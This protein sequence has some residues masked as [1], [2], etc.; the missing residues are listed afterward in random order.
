MRL[1]LVSLS[2]LLTVAVL[3][4]QNA[5]DR[6]TF[7]SGV[8]SIEVDV[9]VT[10]KD[11]KAVRGLTKDAF[12]LI[13]D[14][15]PQRIASFSFIDLPIE[16]IASRVAAAKGVESDITTNAGEGR[17]YVM[18]LN[19]AGERARLVA[20][21]FVEE[22]VGPNDQMAVIHVQGNSSAAQGF[23]KSRRLMLAAVDRID[24]GGEESVGAGADPDPIVANFRVAEEVCEKLGLVTGRR[25]I[26]LWF[27]PPSV[28]IDQSP[29]GPARM[30]A[31]RDALRAATRNNVAVY[32]VSTRGL[33]TDLSPA[34]FPGSPGGPLSY[35]AGLR[36][37]SDDT[38]GETIV[39]T[40]NFSAAFQGFVRDNSSYYLLSYEPAI[41]HRDGK[42]H[43]LTVRV[44]RPGLTVRA[45]RGY[46]APEPDAKAKPDPVVV[47]GLSDAT[48]KAIRMPS[49]IG[50]LGIE[51]LVAPFKGTA[52]NGSVLIGARLRGTDLLLGPREPLEVAFQATTTEGKVTPGAFHVMTLD[53]TPESRAEIERTGIRIV[54]RIELPKGRHQ[55]RFAVHQPNGKTGTV[56]ADV[57]IPDYSAPLV[58]SGVVIAS[59]GAVAHRT[60]L[61]DETFR[62]I[63]S[64]DP[65]PVRRFTRQDVISA[66]AEVYT[67][68]RR[69]EVA[70]VTAS[71]AT[72]NGRKG[73]APTITPV[74]GEPGRGG[75]LTSIRL[76]DLTPG[77]YVLTLDASTARGNA[78]RQ[79]PFTVIAD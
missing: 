19:G 12:T 26:V 3:R 6:P 39:D 45:R 14:D 61:I 75:Y 49:S 77:D 65:T 48:A 10:D 28:F 60:L 64:S 18:L 11:R 35:K 47:E 5:Q 74:S 44:N 46:Y 25:K 40:N 34:G 73:R 72:A 38:G 32:P 13:E 63:L 50:E 42:F 8:Q 27:D 33:T 1:R 37:L 15:T 4:G 55:V 79:V 59:Q 2:L 71:L 78:K 17:M 51:L 23:T 7:R 29:R 53:F 62:S 67:D 69:P 30:F 52:G 24:R 58:M 9:L 43:N 68:P 21:R 41:E 70:R 56:V 31:Q 20:R 16:P 76:A 66:Y 54:D 36:V 57:E 22:V